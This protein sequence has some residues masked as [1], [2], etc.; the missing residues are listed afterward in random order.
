MKRKRFLSA[1]LCAALVF[2]L[3]PAVALAAD[4]ADLT[5]TASVDNPTPS[6]GDT[7]TFAITLINQGPN[8]AT[9]VS[10][11][12]SLQSE[13]SFQ[14]ATPSQGTYDG[15]T[16][17][18]T[19][20][21]IA[22]G[23][24][25]TLQITAT[26]TSAGTI[27]PAAAI[28]SVD[29]YDPECSFY[30]SGGDIVINDAGNG[31]LSVTYGGT[32][33]AP[34]PNTQ[35]ITIGGA[36]TAGTVTVNSGVT[37]KIML[38]GVNIDVSTAEEC[39][40]YIMPDAAVDLTL[41]GNNSL[42]S[43]ASAGLYCNER[44][45]L[46]IG[47]DGTLN[48]TG[49]ENGAGIGGGNGDEGGIIQINSGTVTA[50]G[51]TGGAGL[52]GGWNGRGGSTTIDGGT[53][54]AQ[55][56]TGGAGIG[57]GALGS[58]GT[59]RINDGTVTATGGQTG[60]GIGGGE[61]KPSGGITINGGAV[62]AVSER[63][64]GIGG[65]NGGNG[66]DITINDGTVE[67]SGGDR[68]AGIGGGDGGSCG[69]IIINNGT[70][71]ATGGIGGAGL[72]G[73]YSG[74]GGTIAIM[75]GTV[76]ATGGAATST[77][78]ATGAGIGGGARDASLGG[79][80]GGRIT[81]EGGIVQATGG[82]T[83]DS[84]SGAG[85]GGGGGG[86]DGGEITIRGGNV[87]VRS[88]RYGAGIGG[89]SYSLDKTS[90][91]GEGGIITISGGTIV[92]TDVRVGAG[93]G[94]GVH[95]GGGRITITGGDITARGQGSAAIGGGSHGDGG[96]ISITGG[97]ITA[98]GNGGG[99][100]I[101]G[102]LGATG[103]AIYIGGTADITAESANGAGIGGG[104]YNGGGEITIAGGTVWAASTTGGAGLG[105]GG[106]ETAGSTAVT[107][108]GGTVYAS[109]GSSNQYAGA[110]IGGGDSAEIDA[111]VTLSGGTVYA[112]GGPGA[113]DIGMGARSNAVGTLTILGD[114]AVFLAKDACVPPI[115]TIHAHLTLTEDTQK[116]YGLSIPDE[117]TPVFGAYLRLVALRYD[118]NGGQGTVVP[119]QQHI[120][121]TGQIAGGGFTRT[122]YAFN[123]WST[124]AN[125]SGTAYA[126]G[127]AFAFT[128]NTT[129]WAQWTANS[130]TVTYHLNGGT[131]NPNP[132][133]YTYGTGFVLGVPAREGYIFGGWFSEAAF[134]HKVT[135]IS[136]T[137]TGDVTLYANW[138]PAM[139]TSDGGGVTI[140]LSGVTLP[141]GVTGVSLGSNAI[142]S[143][144]Q[145]YTAV[146]RLISDNASMGGLDK[147]MVYELQ[148][149]DQ[150]GRPIT[151]FAGKI[152]VKIKIPE[153]MSGNLHVYWCDPVTQ[154]LT[155]MNAT[156]Q[157][158]YL[159][160]ETDHFSLY[161]VAQLGAGRSSA[162]DNP[163]I[164]GLPDSFNMYTGGRVS[165]TPGIAGGTWYFDNNYFSA[166]GSP[167]TFTALQS[168]TTAITYTVGWTSKT[169][170]VTIKESRL[171]QTGQDGRWIWILAGAA[172]ALLAT[173]VFIGRGKREKTK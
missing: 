3:T 138:L 132:A 116:A 10:V 128:A 144:G 154:T 124:Q 97:T 100:S 38:N 33:T 55:G 1:L 96:E 172:A 156:V 40:F 92:A 26:V 25:A 7:V 141:E 13:L 103:G 41:A 166:A 35:N 14:S 15:V 49:G 63:G 59:I 136:N 162:P 16:G 155:D 171:P 137:Q 11:S 109:G 135:S 88:D 161:A 148:L 19:V 8:D 83:S 93:I 112:S 121:T 65:G 150:D 159:E 32:T 18:W 139:L 131:D 6:I 120:G 17:I 80:N 12:V 5:V 111:A 69:T 106:E 140:D 67:A 102:G 71:T 94:G 61:Y 68:S 110:G 70:V 158:G 95:A 113:Q 165:W 153:G 37:A 169:I 89:G 78:T 160:F 27:T 29:Q 77:N 145:S 72:G 115:T 60:A 134:Q 51:G 54:A 86:G 130:Y 76:T 146:F 123:G 168:G 23:A 147:L 42:T 84:F 117:W 79:G 81:I 39:A 143:S 31:N 125:G 50:Q 163:D 151:G 85:I 164:A 133:S 167:P 142:P 62:T 101:G 127:D 122:G 9:G 75:N 57:G 24:A 87:T 114:A 56:G 108:T 119:I 22:N 52:G 73:G 98:S 152:K 173:A 20:G 107:I 118:A 82:T 157:N 36:T 126:P 43:G 74:D 28:A 58:G 91:M 105:G 170:S 44:S 2:T 149:L 64:A 48:A 90:D 104:S 45:T 129:L 46:T 30:I 34:F 21:S 47:G 66:G 99:S 4:T 53:V